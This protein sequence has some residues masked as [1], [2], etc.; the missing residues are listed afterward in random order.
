MSG[1]YH[2]NYVGHVN[3]VFG[4]QKILRTSLFPIGKQ[5]QANGNWEK[6]L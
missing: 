5:N 6:G 2:V 4:F 1:I 3:T